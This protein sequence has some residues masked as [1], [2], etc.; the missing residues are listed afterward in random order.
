MLQMWKE[1][2]IGIH[3]SGVDIGQWKKDQG[4]TVSLEV[5]QQHSSLRISMVMLQIW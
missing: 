2:C 3:T 5:Q 1:G 4:G